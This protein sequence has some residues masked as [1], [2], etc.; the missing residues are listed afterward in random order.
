MV[1]GSSFLWT[2]PLKSVKS[3]IY[4]TDKS[5]HC[6]ANSL[7]ANLDKIFACAKKPS[8]TQTMPV[9]IK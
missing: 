4:V 5:V 3:W 2:S 9:D 7:V 8:S 6:C 1:N